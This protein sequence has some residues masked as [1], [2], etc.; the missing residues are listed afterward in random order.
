[1]QPLL[2]GTHSWLDIHVQWY[3]HTEHE[4]KEPWHAQ[5]QLHIVACIVN[6]QGTL[7]VSQSFGWK[8]DMFNAY[9]YLISQ[10]IYTV[11]R[12]LSIVNGSLPPPFFVYTHAH[13][14][15]IQGV[16]VVTAICKLQ[17]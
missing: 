17:H 13:A 5:L 3:K 14:G 9:E 6:R 12:L 2:N 10:D 8:H 15:T 1:V 7:S 16:L 4:V 11:Q